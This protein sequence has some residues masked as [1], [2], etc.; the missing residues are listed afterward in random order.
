[1]EALTTLGNEM[2]KLPYLVYPFNIL[3]KRAGDDKMAICSLTE[4][5]VSDND[6][7]SNL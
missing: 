1:L 5:L 6:Y 3:A 7:E 4:D 2:G